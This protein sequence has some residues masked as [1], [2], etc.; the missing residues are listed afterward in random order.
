MQAKI[1][2]D[3]WLVS[4]EEEGILI[5][6]P[7]IPDQPLRFK[8]K[9]EGDLWVQYDISLFPISESQDEKEPIE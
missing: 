8:T 2:K 3:G 5:D 6:V 1:D 7:Y 4:G 9:R